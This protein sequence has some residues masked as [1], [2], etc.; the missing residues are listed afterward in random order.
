MLAAAPDEVELLV[1]DHNMPG[2]T[3][4]ALAAEVRRLHPGLPV[5]LT[6]GYLS[7]DLHRGAVALGDVK[8]LNK[9]DSF[10]KLSALIDAMLAMR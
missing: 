5:I 10:D 7:E 9:E 2:M 1:T 8:L 4:L 3:G 6:S